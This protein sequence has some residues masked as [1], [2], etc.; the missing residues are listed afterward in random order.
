[1]KH[2]FLALL[3][4]TLSVTLSKKS[5]AQTATSARTFRLTQ[6]QWGSFEAA[7]SSLAM[8]SKAG[9]IFEGS[10]HRVSLNP[11]HIRPEGSLSLL[12]LVKRLAAEYDYDAIQRGNLF[13]LTKQY[14]DASD[15]PPVTLPECAL[16]MRDAAKIMRPLFTDPPQYMPALGVF[17]NRFVYELSPE[18]LRQA[19]DGSLMAVK[20]APNL[21]GH[22]KGLFAYS[23]LGSNWGLANGLAQQITWCLDKGAWLSAGSDRN[24]LVFQY[25]RD[26]DQ[27]NPRGQRFGEGIVTIALEHSAGVLPNAPSSLDAEPGNTFLLSEAA[28][29]YST[30]NWLI[31]IDEALA[32]KSVTLIGMEMSKHSAQQ[33][34]SGLAFVHGLRA[35]REKVGVT[36]ITRPDLILAP[37]LDANAFSALRKALPAGLVHAYLSKPIIPIFQSEQ[38]K[39]QFMENYDLKM[40]EHQREIG[41]RAL[42]VLLKAYQRV[43]KQGKDKITIVELTPMER[44]ALAVAL[45]G[46]IMQSLI[47]LEGDP[48]LITHFDDLLVRCTISKNEEGSQKISIIVAVPSEQP[49][50]LKDVGGFLGAPYYLD[51]PEKLGLPA[52]NEER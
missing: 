29:K 22:L 15:L 39:R 18:Q 8:Q 36:K 31:Q 7:F 37:N 20:T 40:F 16:A 49:G 51:R 13:L 44:S 26:P 30:N 34:A 5:P 45:T 2:F 42:D 47:T 43:A 46:Q 35:S 10:P 12:S 21:Q 38:E 52:K 14:H 17:I 27:L 50:K 6:A 4:C 1:M 23:Y 48:F 9:F 19:N 33:I 28:Q 41:K 11:T 32:E 24:N 3:A 25:N